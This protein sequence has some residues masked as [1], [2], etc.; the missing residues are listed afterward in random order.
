MLFVCLLL[1]VLGPWLTMPD[2][3]WVYRPIW[4]GKGPLKLLE[5]KY[6]SGEVGERTKHESVQWRVW[7]NG[8][9]GQRRPWCLG[10]SV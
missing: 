3:I 6:W 5:Y 8:P 9:I 2:S 10:G 1:S 4:V 7:I